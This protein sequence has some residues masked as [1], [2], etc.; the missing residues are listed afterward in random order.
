M[1]TYRVHLVTVASHTVEVEAEDGDAAIE[2][3]LRSEHPYFPGGMDGDL[4]EWTTSSELFP[5]IS[6]PESDYELISEGG[7]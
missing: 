3:A 7:D 4:G 2:V 1:A 6:K 5:D